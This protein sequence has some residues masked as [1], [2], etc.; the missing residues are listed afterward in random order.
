[1]FA[2]S[3]TKSIATTRTQNL[4]K[5]P[6]L[7]FFLGPLLVFSVVLPTGSLFEIPFKQLAYL[8]TLT[9][10]VV[11]WGQGKVIIDRWVLLVSIL[12]SG[13]TLFFVLIGAFQSDLFGLVLR[14]ASGVFTAVTVVLLILTCIASG[15]IS[16]ER[17]VAYVF[18]GTF[19]F[20]L[21]KVALAF[22][23]VLRIVSFSQ[24]YN[25][26][27]DQAGYRIVSSGIF[28]GLVRINLIVYDFLVTLMLVIL[29][30][31][32]RCL[33]HIPKIHRAAFALVASACIVFAFSR[34][35]FGLVLLGF[36]YYFIFHLNF[37]AKLA[38]CFFLIFTAILSANW[39]VGAFEQRFRSH[40]A[41]A[42]DSIR[43]DQI[44][45]LVNE[46]SKSPLIGHGFGAYSKSVIRDP[47]VPYS[48]EVQW[49]GFLAK[50]GS[51]GVSILLL[52]V[53]SLY[54][55]ILAGTRS[56][57]HY[58]LLMTLSAFVLGGLSNQY[59]ASSASGVVYCL[60]VIFAA[61]LRKTNSFKENK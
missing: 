43:T 46:W 27:I 9:L 36:I 7:D 3:R 24:V 56:K 45:A 18:Y 5:S 32:P 58:I 17:V 61:M 53:G 48:Y 44:V 60:H 19:L 31:A 59:L 34:L 23:L 4:T 21:W 29:L 13:F 41:T 57:E 49:V 25:F 22:S 39:L 51:V 14:E 37:R 8:A 55:K 15:L 33:T 42:S 38:V 16:N 6:L 1:L 50:L 40:E 10:L 35:L 54:W 2:I 28:G 30:T 47:Q 12:F 26:L 20:A 11:F 52:M